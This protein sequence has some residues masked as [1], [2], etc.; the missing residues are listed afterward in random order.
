MKGCRSLTDE[1]IGLVFNTLK[2]QRDKVLFSLGLSTGL[3]ISELL[4]LTIGDVL[5]HGDVGSQVTVAKKNTKGKIESKTLPI[6]EPAKEQL[7]E[8]LDQLKFFTPKDPL[9]RSTQSKRSITRIQAHRILKDAFN[10]LQL[11]GN[12]STHCLRKTFA[13]RVHKQMG[14]NIEMTKVALCH[15]NLSSTASYIQ[16]NE[17]EVRK[18][19]LSIGQDMGKGFV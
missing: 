17:E 13:H 18:A 10:T 5:E 9:F 12:L 15:K 3:R 8:Y 2:S 6:S 7:K 1:E 4:S 14:G 19:I 11:K 16:V